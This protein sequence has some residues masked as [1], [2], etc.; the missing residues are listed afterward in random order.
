MP[1]TYTPIA[2][3]TL[4]SS[5]STVTFSSIPSTYTDLRIVVIGNG[6]VNNA[7]A[8]KFNSDTGTNYSA[9]E[10]YGNGTS[11]GSQRRTSST[12]FPLTIWGGLGTAPSLYTIDIFSYA[13][14]STYKTSIVSGN[15]PT[16]TYASTSAL[17]GLWRSTAAINQIDFIDITWI[18]GTTFTL[19]G[20]KAA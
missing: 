13:N 16:G 17:V 20:I 19:Y 1:S 14:T 8:I 11:A 18:A 6:T 5:A 12:Q 10:L 9:T 7:A 15:T 2:T 3:Q 4:G